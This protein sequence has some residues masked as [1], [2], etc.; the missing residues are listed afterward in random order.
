MTGR[1]ALRVVVGALV[2]LLFAAVAAGDAVEFAPREASSPE[3]TGRTGDDSSP[4]TVDD[5]PQAAPIVADNTSG[6]VPAAVLLWLGI[7]GAALVALS[8][9]SLLREPLAKLVRSGRW[10]PFGS[11]PRADVEPLP[12]VASAVVD[13]AEAQRAELL[14]GE[15]RNAI[16]RCWLRLEHDVASVG[17]TRHRAQTSAEFTESVLAGYSVD[18]D[19]IHT[20][21][22]LYREARF[23]RHDLDE[24]TR[25]EALD[26][27]D[28]LHRSLTAAPAD[29]PT[30]QLVDHR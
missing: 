7:T 3:A 21:A 22:R 26:A 2:A 27:L 4:T 9:L 14:A 28:R 25:R 8:V 6:R 20:L 10:W 18:G 5:T 1:G 29:Q 16:V 13:E 15:P 12:D 30:S 24:P 17:L 23:S 11:G 19:A